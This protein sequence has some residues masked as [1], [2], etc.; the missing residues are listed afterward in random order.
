[1]ARGGKISKTGSQ[2]AVSRRTFPP[3]NRRSVQDLVTN[4]PS[5]VRTANPQPG[6]AQQGRHQPNQQPVHQAPPERGQ[7]QAVHPPPHEPGQVRV[8]HNEPGSENPE[9]ENLPL[10]DRYH[11]SV[12]PPS[13]PNPAD[14]GWAS[15]RRLGGWKAF[16]VEFPMLEE[17]SEQHKGAWCTAWKASL[18]RW[19]ESSNEYDTETALLWMGFWAQCLQR[20]PSRGGRQGR[21]E[22]A[23]RYDCVIQGD[24]S[25]LVDRW[26]RDKKKRDEK[27]AAK[28]GSRPDRENVE[29]EQRELG[30]QRKVVIGL[31]QAGQLGKAMSRVNSHG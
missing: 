7:A 3:L 12:P 25:G 10:E 19:K 20:K 21:V 23:N 26:E 13:E 11:P 16:L 18:S 5:L 31:I 2:P 15:I 17:I 1:M 14:G 30:I 9:V 28:R 4:W 6:V 27:L 22:V 8:P 24:W 29:T